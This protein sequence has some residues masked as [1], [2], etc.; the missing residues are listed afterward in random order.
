MTNCLA[1]RDDGSELGEPVE[2]GL[3]ASSL[4]GNPV[5]R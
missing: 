2:V 5:W 4:V 1:F 3:G